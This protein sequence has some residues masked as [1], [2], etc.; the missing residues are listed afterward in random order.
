[1]SDFHKHSAGIARGL[2]AFTQIG[3]STAIPVVFFIWGA[4]WLQKKFGLGNWV[5][6][7]G[8]VLG[9]VSGL[10]TFYKEAMLLAGSRPGRSDDN[11]GIR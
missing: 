2:S 10:F 9:I 8:I 11:E 7:A 6:I 5:L 3:V 4:A 1:M